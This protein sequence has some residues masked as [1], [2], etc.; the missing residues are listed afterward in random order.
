MSNVAPRPASGLRL[1]VER[2]EGAEG[3]LV[4][5][6][7]VFLPDSEHAIHVEVVNGSAR[8]VLEGRPDLEGMCAALVRAAA[9]GDAPPH[10]I[11]RWRPL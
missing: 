5:R 1:W 6:G 9:K 11:V 4:Y 7:Q 3:A 2:V 10:K 8:A